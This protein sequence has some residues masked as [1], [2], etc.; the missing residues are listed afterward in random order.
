METNNDDD[1]EYL[2][3]I[4]KFNDFYELGDSVNDDILN[5]VERKIK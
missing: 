4:N 3:K 2:N 1:K 5:Y